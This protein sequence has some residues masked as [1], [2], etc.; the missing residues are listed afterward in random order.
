MSDTITAVGIRETEYGE[1][2]VL[3]SPYNAKDFI[4]AL[5]WKALSEEREEHG[6]FRAKLED[7]DVA[8]GA[9]DAAEDFDFPDDFAAHPRWDSDALDGDGAWLVDFDSWSVARDFFEFS[10][11]D[12]EDNNITL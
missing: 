1:K 12:V 3:D 7:R 5:P 9:I 10:G 2:V 4:N 11:F 6:S 8:N